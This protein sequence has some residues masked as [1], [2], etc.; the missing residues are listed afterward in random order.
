M[1]TI[2]IEIDFDGGKVALLIEAGPGTGKT[3]IVVYLIDRLLSEGYYIVS[4]AVT[5]P[6]VSTLRDRIMEYSEQVEP[7]EIKDIVRTFASLGINILQIDPKSVFE[8]VIK[9]LIMYGKGYLVRDFFRER[10][11]LNVNPRALLTDFSVS[12]N[13][14]RGDEL[15][16]HLLNYT[17]RNE[18][19]IYLNDS[20]LKRNYESFKKKTEIYNPKS[21]KLNYDKFVDFY[22]KIIKDIENG[23]KL[24]NFTIVTFYPMIYYR[25]M[26]DYKDLFDFALVDEFNESGRME[27]EMMKNLARRLIIVGNVMQ[28]IYS[29]HDNVSVINDAFEIAKKRITLTTQYRIYSNIWNAIRKYS[30]NFA[31]EIE[32]LYKNR[33]L[34]EFVLGGMKNTEPINNGGFYRFLLVR[35]DNEAVELIRAFI[36]KFGVENTVVLTRR[37]D[38]SRYIDRKLRDKKVLLEF[39]EYTET[40]LNKLKIMQDTDIDISFDETYG[41]LDERIIRLFKLHGFNSINKKGIKV[42]FG[43][44]DNFLKFVFKDRYENAKKYLRN[45]D[46]FVSAKVTTIHKMKGKERQNVIV[47][48]DFPKSFIEKKVFMNNYTRFYEKCVFFVGM[49][50]AIQNLVVISKSY[51]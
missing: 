31:K 46:L 49:T 15:Y 51:V 23:F 48:F 37:R 44:I 10:Y 36:N 34:A 30:F 11:R 19:E 17:L 25:A 41:V 5:R 43:G 14:M 7:R 18:A 16:F 26:K 38:V 45:D 12:V 22:E 21:H 39:D 40:F 28:S 9:D 3:Q 42:V 20:A 33:K 47:Y 50:R 24:G 2:T 13:E 35:N 6:A 8:N 27:Y 1:R 32:S 4:T 29:F